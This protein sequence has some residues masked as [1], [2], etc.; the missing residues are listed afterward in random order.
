[1]CQNPRRARKGHRGSGSL[2]WDRARP[3]VTELRGC[4]DSS[5]FRDHWERETFPAMGWGRAR[6]W[7]M[8]HRRPALLHPASPWGSQTRCSHLSHSLTPACDK[9]VRD[10]PFHEKQQ[11]KTRDVPE[12]IIWESDGLS[13]QVSSLQGSSE[14]LL[15]WCA[16]WSSK[17]RS[18]R[19]TNPR[20]RD[21]FHGVRQ[22]LLLHEA[23]DL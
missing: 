20:T 12:S 11:N 23:S 1:M 5:Q 9:K 6:A 18:R 3:G 21:A 15:C 13:K 17:G 16:L 14:S 19:M 22:E 4:A 2:Q 10:A 8:V 7:R